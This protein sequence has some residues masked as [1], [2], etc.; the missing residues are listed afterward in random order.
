MTNLR[1]LML[2]L[3]FVLVTASCE[4][5]DIDPPVSN[6][7]PVPNFPAD[8]TVF[9]NV[10]DGAGI[11]AGV[12]LNDDVLVVFDQSGGEYA[13]IENGVVMDKRRVEDA[14]SLF[15][16]LGNDYVSAAVVLKTSLYLF[17]TSGGD[18]RAVRIADI[19]KVKGK[20]NQPDFFT[21]LNT[22]YL[23]RAWGTDDSCPFTKISAAMG[24]HP[25]RKCSNVD[26]GS[27][28]FFF[29]KDEKQYSTYSAETSDFQS[30]FSNTTFLLHNCTDQSYA[31]LNMS[32]QFDATF[33]YPVNNKIYEVF[34]Y[35]GGLEFVYSEIGSGEIS[36]PYRIAE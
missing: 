5:E 14:K 27:R 26:R 15:N 12:W 31:H 22:S 1:F 20:W 2:F 25:E 19:T 6:Q 34:F 24:W 9:Q 16:S 30:S 35:D 18:Y 33:I 10:F 23:L 36:K 29:D 4:K 28:L 3:A 17:G 13:W 7:N 11:G 32:K 8:F 21:P